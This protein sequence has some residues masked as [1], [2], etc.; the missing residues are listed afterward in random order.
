MEAS[1]SFV[2]VQVGPSEWWRSEQLQLQLAQELMGRLGL[3]PGGVV[4]GPVGVGGEEDAGALVHELHH[5]PVRR[6]RHARLATLRMGAELIS[7][8][9]Q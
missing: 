9:R 7:V 4:A 1:E 8:T 2:Q 6:P 3:G 5:A